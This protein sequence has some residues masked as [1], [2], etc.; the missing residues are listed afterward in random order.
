MKTLFVIVLQGARGGEGPGGLNGAQ[1]ISVSKC[2]TI[3]QKLTTKT[4]LNYEYMKLIYLN[5]DIKK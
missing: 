3:L 4:V 1:G 5:C 2:D